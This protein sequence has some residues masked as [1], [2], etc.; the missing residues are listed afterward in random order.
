M[1]RFIHVISLS[2]FCL[3]CGCTTLDTTRGNHFDVP[4]PD[5][6]PPTW[7]D[8]T[9]SFYDYDAEGNLRDVRNDLSGR[10]TGMVQF[11]QSHSVDPSGNEEKHM[12]RMTSEREALLLFTPSPEFDDIGQLEVTV[13]FNG[14]VEET[15]AL[16]RPE[17]ILKADRPEDAADSRPDIVYSK[18]AWSAI[19]PWHVI[20]PGM[21]LVFKDGSGKEGRLEAE[22]IEMAPPSELVLNNIRIGL[23]T[24]PPTN[25]DHYMMLEPA[26]AGADYFQTAPLSKM[27]IAQYEDI[28]LD[29]VIVATGEIYENASRDEGGV[30]SGDMREN[31]AKSTFSV[32]I[33]LANWGITS[34]GMLSQQQPQLTQTVVSHHAQ[35]EYS[36]GTQ[37]HG[38]SG[39]N[40]MLTLVRSIGNEFSHEIGH[41]YGLGHY[42]GRDGDDDFWTTH[43]HDSG[44]GYIAHRK[45]MRANIHWTDQQ[46][47]DGSTNV[48]NFKDTYRFSRDAMS[49]G[50]IASQY[51]DYTHYTGYSTQIRIQP[52][53]NRPV[54][55]EE[56]PSGY[57]IWNEE[58]G[59]ME[60]HR[61]EVPESDYIWF[62]TPDGYYLPP[63]KHGTDVY[64][65]LGGYD[66]DEQIGLLYPPARSN[67]GNVFDLPEPDFD[68]GTKQCWLQI[69][70][71]G[72]AVMKVALSP[73]RMG[74]NANK[75]HVQVD[76]DENPRH[77]LLY[78]QSSEGE[79]VLL[80]EVEFP[81]NTP[82]MDPPVVI[83]REAGYRA[84]EKAENLEVH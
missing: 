43:H 11:V 25:E 71:E 64:T 22:A 29:K 41:H 3:I 46:L 80:S 65:V 4:V 79:R 61:P 32:G 76:A 17:F 54:F 27:T 69:D 63:A 62:N 45:K 73:H 38:L 47:S 57:R 15:L 78:C 9:L 67:W 20:K 1:S 52:S 31:T 84:L 58:T 12:P 44:W 6:Q 82:K 48:P 35:G 42:P 7:D 37:L 75:L 49:G 59:K 36:N 30:Y 50:D 14:K 16:S 2:L 53:L 24:D 70:Y 10:L 8:Q 19:L 21:E 33:N 39:G 23:L 55:S 66:P 77:A 13:L 34:S 28:R 68:S 56:S 72:G 83:G 5:H 40:G 81:V 74:S 51:S 18:R 60:N 26:K